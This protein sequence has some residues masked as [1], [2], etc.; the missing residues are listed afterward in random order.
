MTHDENHMSTKTITI[1]AR[2]EDGHYEYEVATNGVTVMDVSVPGRRQLPPSV[3]NL[4]LA[5]VEEV[6]RDPQSHG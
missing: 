5:F 3:A 2:G 1:T 6:L 4:I